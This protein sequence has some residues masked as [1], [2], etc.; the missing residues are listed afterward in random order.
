MVGPLMLDGTMY[1]VPM[2]TMEGALIAFTNR[3]CCAII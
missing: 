1:M 2:S 3:G